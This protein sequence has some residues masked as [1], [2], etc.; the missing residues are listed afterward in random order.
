MMS[1]DKVVSYKRLNKIGQGSYGKVYR[2]QDTQ[3]QYYAAKVIRISSE[4]GL[5]SLL[6]LSI[7]R[8]YSHRCLSSS[9]F[10]SIRREKLYVIQDLASSDLDDRV[11][12]RLPEIETHRIWCQEISQGV[13]VLHRN[14]IIHCDLKPSNCLFFDGHIKVAD[15]TQSVL[16]LNKD[17]TFNHQI[18]TLPYKAPEVLF[19]QSWN[20]TVDIWAMGCTFYFIF[21][22]KLLIPYQGA[23]TRTPDAEQRQV[24]REKTYSSIVA[25]RRTLGDEAAE[26]AVL[27]RLDFLKVEIDPRWNDLPEEMQNL[28]LSMTQFDPKLRPCVKDIV[29]HPYFS[30][31]PLYDLVIHGSYCYPLNS[32]I[33]LIL[34]RIISKISTRR[35]FQDLMVPITKL[36]KELYSRCVNM[37]SAIIHC[38]IKAETCLWMACKILTGNGCPITA[39]LSKIIE[40]EIEICGHLSYTLHVPMYKK[41]ISYIN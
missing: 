20:E 38:P 37:K 41:L 4:R 22:G 40:M 10:I 35:E 29:L 34:D 1:C 31:L 32:K 3:G 6:E 9:P 13:D 21:T 30:K 16:K 23:K 18:G 39:P 15:F 19:N 25:W 12:Q 27:S 36:T 26:K 2:V 17:D 8:S 11:T 24:S 28:I 14:D 5:P 7:L 33:N